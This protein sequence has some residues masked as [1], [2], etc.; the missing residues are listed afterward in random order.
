MERWWN[1]T[2]EKIEV[3]WGRNLPKFHFSITNPKRTCLGSNLGFR[4][5]K[6][7]AKLIKP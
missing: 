2:D 1:D 6:P 7:V 5:E 4:Y 3:F